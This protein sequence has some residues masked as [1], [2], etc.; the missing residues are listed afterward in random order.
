MKIKYVRHPG[1]TYELSEKYTIQTDIYP[2]R[3]QIDTRSGVTLNQNGLL[4]IHPG[5]TWDGA[6]GGI[7]TDNFMRASLVHD[8][9]YDLMRWGSLPSSYRKNADKL[10]RDIC[11]ED[12]MS[13][14]R[15]WRSYMYVRVFGGRAWR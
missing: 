14:W 15:A 10:L 7:D 5:Y 4:V 11:I 12:G 6:T 9:L 3:N 13:K 2:K 1:G 8:A